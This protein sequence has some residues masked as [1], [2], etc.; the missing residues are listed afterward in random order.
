MEVARLVSAVEAAEALG[1]SER[2]IRR[3]IHAGVL[4]GVRTGRAFEIDLSAAR[5]VAGR[6]RR[7]L[8]ESTDP[9]VEI[10]AAELEAL[11]QRVHQLEGAIRAD[12]IRQRA[13]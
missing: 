9:R 13:A 11:R 5:A 7:R 10:L 4:T 8:M 3:W 1:V 12:V 2:T 6:Q